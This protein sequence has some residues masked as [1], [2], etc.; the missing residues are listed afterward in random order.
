[1]LV[2]VKVVEGILRMPGVDKIAM[3][4]VPVVRMCLEVYNFV[5]LVGFVERF[6]YAM[7]WGLPISVS[8][9]GVSI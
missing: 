9:Q 5:L 1:M 4:S 6:P 8:V 7:V 2:A 3:V